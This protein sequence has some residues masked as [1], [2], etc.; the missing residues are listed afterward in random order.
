MRWQFVTPYPIRRLPSWNHLYYPLDVREDP[1]CPISTRIL[2]IANLVKR[3]SSQKETPNTYLPTWIILKHDVNKQILESSVIHPSLLVTKHSRKLAHSLLLS[4]RNENQS[5]RS[6]LGVR[7]ITAVE[8]TSLQLNNLV[9][10]QSLASIVHNH[11][12]LG[13]RVM[14]ND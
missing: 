5:G 8:T 10:L 11:S 4:I 3:A 9:L 7:H 12:V 1:S 14:N 2:K 13:V 6:I